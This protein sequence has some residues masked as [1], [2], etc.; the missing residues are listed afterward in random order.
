MRW[1][2]Y[3][4]NTGQSFNSFWQDYLSQKNRDVLFVLGLGFD[5][6]MCMG[7]E[8]LLNA[9]GKGKRDCRIAKFVG[10]TD[11]SGEKYKQ[12]VDANLAKLEKLIPVGSKKDFKEISSWSSDNRRITSTSAADFFNSF[13]DFRGYS[14]IIIDVSAM[15]RTVFFSLIGKT[16]ALLDIREKENVNN[17][18]PNLFVLVSENAFLDNRIKDAGID[19]DANYLH[20][21]TSTLETETYAE[22]PKIWIP[23]LGENQRRQ[24]SIIAHKV[25]PQ[26]VCPVLPMPATDPRRADNLLIEYNDLLF[27]EIMVEPGNFIY[28]SEQNPFEVYRAIHGTVR[29][30]KAALETLGGCQIVLSASSSK[31]LS[32]GVLLAGYEL[33]EER[34]GVI[35]VET[36]EYEIEDDISNV[37]EKTVLSTLWLSGEC[38]RT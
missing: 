21:F 30:Y 10:E 18:L 7:Y 14:D 9:G 36:R 19:E 24:L 33:R 25:S 27:L 37:N 12:L 17:E 13:D 22:L 26:E 16:L 11:S 34:V 5:P 15:P 3:F 20:G 31:L 29:K 28:V 35:N 23:T 4:F 2:N 1:S 6:R 8:A 32:L 38:Y